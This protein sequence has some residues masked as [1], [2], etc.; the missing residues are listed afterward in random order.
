MSV[1][2]NVTLPDYDEDIQIL[3]QAQ[4]RNAT[5]IEMLYEKLGMEIPED[6]Q[7]DLQ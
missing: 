5:L 6:P 1:N 4:N 3:F 2:V 7:E